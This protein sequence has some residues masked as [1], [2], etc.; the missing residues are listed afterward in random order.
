MNSKDYLEQS[1]RTAS[2]DYEA[3]TS[4]LVNKDM[5]GLLHAGMGL[6]T[7]SSEFIDAL[8]KHLFYGKELDTVN[9]REEIGDCLW[10]LA[11]ALRTLDSDFDTEMK[12]N[13]EKLQARFPTKFTEEGAEVRDLNKE[14]EI[15]ER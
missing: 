9:L 10:Y 7:E 12:I 15:L 8:K 1:A 4:R 2:G 14:R 13:I 6:A 5:V 11:L 3:I